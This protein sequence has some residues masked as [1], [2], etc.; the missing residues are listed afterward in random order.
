MIQ[1]IFLLS[2]RA[3]PGIFA[4]RVQSERARGDPMSEE[5]EC[6][7]QLCGISTYLSADIIS[8]EDPA[9]T[10]VKLLSSIFVCEHCGGQLVL[11]GK[12]GDEP[13][14]RLE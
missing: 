11:V 8:L 4:Q 3:F 9:N 10:E 6:M 7:C 1:T 5:M 14:Y 2:G 13:Y 12:A